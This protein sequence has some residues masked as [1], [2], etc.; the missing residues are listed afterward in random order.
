M[1]DNRATRELCSLDPC[2]SLVPSNCGPPRWCPRI[3]CGCSLGVAA[4]LAFA[5]GIG[6]LWSLRDSYYEL[7]RDP[8]HVLQ[9][10]KL[11]ALKVDCAELELGADADAELGDDPLKRRTIDWRPYLA[12]PGRAS[13][14]TLSLLLDTFGPGKLTAQEFWDNHCP[15]SLLRKFFVEK[16][17]ENLRSDRCAFGG[18]AALA[19]DPLACAGGFYE[20]RERRNVTWNESTGA[21]ALADT[22]TE[23]GLV[24]K[25]LP[26]ALQNLSLPGNASADV[27]NV[28]AWAVSTAAAP[29][30]YFAPEFQTCLIRCARGGFCPSSSTSVDYGQ[31][32]S[33]ASGLCIFPWGLGGSWPMSAPPSRGLCPGSSSL[34]LCPA[35]FYCPQPTVMHEC[36]AGHVCPRGSTHAQRCAWGAVCAAASDWPDYSR[37]CWVFFAC[38][39]G[40]ALFV[41][42]VLSVNL[43]DRFP[44]TARALGRPRALDRR[45]VNAARARF[46]LAADA[47][48]DVPP[49][50]GGDF[51]VHLRIA[52]LAGPVAWALAVASLFDNGAVLAFLCVFGV[53]LY[54]GCGLCHFD[55]AGAAARD[56]YPVLVVCGVPRRSHVVVAATAG[57][58]LLVAVV[59]VL[60]R[61]GDATWTLVVLAAA[62]AATTVSCGAAGLL[63]FYRSSAR[64]PHDD[65]GGKHTCDSASAKAPSFPRRRHRRDDSTRRCAKPGCKKAAKHTCSVCESVYYCSPQHQLDHW[66]AHKQECSAATR[67]APNPPPHDDDLGDDDS[68]SNADVDESAS[69]SALNR[70]LSIPFDDVSVSPSEVAI[71]AGDVEIRIDLAFQD[72][73]LRLRSDG[74]TVLSNATG[75]IDSG[76]VTAIMG[77]SGAGKT[78]LMNVLA[79]RA[80]GY[81]VVEG[82]MSVL[83]NGEHRS[84]SLDRWSTLSAFV[85]QDDVM[86]PELTVRQTIAFYAS[87]RAPRAVSKAQ[88]DNKVCAALRTVRL[89]PTVWDSTI[90]DAEMRGISGGQK[91][92]VNVAME[93]VSDPSL[94]FLDEPTS[95]LDSTTSRHIVEALNAQARRGVNVVVVL[96]QPSFPIFR[97]FTHVLLLG[98]GGRV[99][100]HGGPEA[101]EAYFCGDLGYELPPYANPADFYLEL[102]SGGAAVVVPD[103]RRAAAPSSEAPAASG[104]APAA[105]VPGVTPRAAA[106][107]HLAGEWGQRRGVSH[108]PILRSKSV[109]D[110]PVAPAARGWLAMVALFAHRALLQ[111]A[112]KPGTLAF[113]V[114]LMAAAGF[115]FGAQ[116]EKVEPHSLSMMVL[117]LG[118]GLQLVVA[119]SSLR[120]FSPERVV[121]WR[122][123]A[124]GS[125]MALSPSAYFLG[126]DLVQLPRLALMVLA[127]GVPFYAQA[128]PTPSLSYYFLVFYLLAYAV[129]GYAYVA[130]ML[131]SLK[132]A[133]LLIVVTVLVL[134]MLAPPAETLYAA[135]KSSATRVLA[136]LA[137]VR[138]AGEALFTAQTRR[139]SHAWKMPP[140]FYAKPWKHSAL[141]IL[142]RFPFHEGWLRDVVPRSAQIKFHVVT[143]T[144]RRG[145]RR[146]RGRRT[147][148]SASSTVGGSRATRSICRSC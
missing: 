91:K 58:L 57:P 94:L 35:K 90:G 97:S 46:G 43:L 3:R 124:R 67:A 28:S 116:S 127:F 45:I 121:F 148:A 54:G 68:A 63:T 39:A 31:L 48:S 51:A 136:W 144:R 44:R 134:T 99:V 21:S 14:V 18:D 23:F 100:Y 117:W 92:R 83:V 13:N 102:I 15:E 98:V 112:A 69:S 27:H 40:L 114:S 60:V 1:R 26:E 123:C 75:A 135:D 34:H 137:P 86:L 70:R 56:D 143:S 24:R 113:D 101:A 22:A 132:D 145:V 96:H 147:A 111:E 140:L 9:T 33:W 19:T 52:A 4:A 64:G 20:K 30:G 29:P 62:A 6:T 73:G 80:G 138:W 133:Q 8:Y 89:R 36:P 139:L 104:R 122:E 5:A 16:K 110:G 50:G 53:V 41:R 38:V 107:Q 119:V 42:G 131:C 11:K 118:I 55:V 105:S 106:S 47:G 71:D 142:Y 85:P 103:R 88:L 66:P 72:L 61:E 115:V 126:K 77:P 87:I 10:V 17:P 2:R 37:A 74:R 95:G 82:T 109:D 7:R 32:P 76:C 25:L 130:S 128:R 146:F 108:P 81:G 49:W 79:G 78:T 93:I 129:S 84:S 59:A 120:V 12:D 141:Y 65:N 125:G